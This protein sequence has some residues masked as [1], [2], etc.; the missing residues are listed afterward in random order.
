MKNTKKSTFIAICFV[1]LAI[2]ASQMY[3]AIQNDN[4]VKEEVAVISEIRPT[5]TP[6]AT[7]KISKNEPVP[8]PES[9]PVPETA[10]VSVAVP[11]ASPTPSPKSFLL[12]A[13]GEVQRPFSDT[14][15]V[16]F[17]PLGIWRCHL[18]IDFLP[19]ENDIVFAAADGTVENI[20]E[21]PLYGTTVLVDHGDAIKSYY[22]SLSAV[23]VEIGASVS[24]GT[25]L[26]HMGETAPAESGI[27]LHF[28]MEKDG[29]PIDP[30]ARQE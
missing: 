16:R 12:P 26:G 9:T 15:L 14:Q 22:S 24:A 8:V 29:N 13:T 20:Y 23:S 18:G 4:A 30:F 28:A 11:A 2:L 25:E 1:A 21:D 6:I 19:S 17:E 5:V 3:K 10:S 7:P 27:H